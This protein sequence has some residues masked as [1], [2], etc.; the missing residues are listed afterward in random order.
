MPTTV[1]VI[2][3]DWAALW[4][5]PESGIMHHYF[6]KP[7]QGRNFRETLDAGLQVMKER[8]ATRWLSDDRNISA[9]SPEDAEWAKAWGIRASE[10]GWRC[11]AIVLPEYV[12]GKMDMARYIAAQRERG[13]NVRLF[14][15]PDEALEWLSSDDPE[16][17]PFS[18]DAR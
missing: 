14:S 3:N 6:K 15:D 13:L 2:D 1:T 4:Y 10:A 8:G 12:I 11:W 18:S 16:P 7:V 17:Y 9:L 5:H